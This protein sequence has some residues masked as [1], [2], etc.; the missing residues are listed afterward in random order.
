MRF[1]RQTLGSRIKVS[2][3]C[4]VML[5]GALHFAYGHLPFPG[6]VKLY[7][8]ADNK[9]NTRLFVENEM[10]GESLEVLKIND[11]AMSLSFGEGL[12]TF[13]E[14]EQQADI[15]FNAL[16]APLKNADAKE[17]TRTKVIPCG[18]TVGVK[19]KTDGIMVFGC[20]YVNGE[21]GASHKPAEDFVIPGDLILSVNGKAVDNNEQLREEIQDSADGVNM[22]IKREEEILEVFIMPVMCIDDGINKI[23]IWVRDSTQGIGTVTYINPEIRRVRPRHNGCGYEKAYER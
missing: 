7:A 1:K 2:V 4:T 22:K 17:N 13:T 19:I 9:I 5:T 20:G 23:G 3:I 15:D 8:N 18:M 6:A 12:T 14:G 16:E 21:D 11:S 10:I